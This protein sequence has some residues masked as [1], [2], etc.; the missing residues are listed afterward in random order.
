MTKFKLLIFVGVI[1]L[2]GIGALV[3]YFYKT[4][5]NNPAA[6][7]SKDNFILN[8]FQAPAVEG[9]IINSGIS[10]KVALGDGRA[11]E[12]FLD[13]FSNSDFSK[14]FISVRTH[15][16]GTFQIP[17]RPGNY[18]LKPMDPDGPIAP[19][20]DSYNFTIGSGQWLQVKVEYD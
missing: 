10:G 2:A 17:L 4:S 3:F 8:T 6:P 18:V 11:L 5:Q 9:N 13:I 16:D 12:V 7:A 14:P 20:R 15:D 19:T 1:I